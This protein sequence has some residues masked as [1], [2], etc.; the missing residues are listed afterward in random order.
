MS[1]VSV[2]VF[3]LAEYDA[4]HELSRPNDRCDCVRSK[5]DIKY[6]FKIY[7]MKYEN[8]IREIHMTII[9]P[10]AVVLQYTTF[11]QCHQGI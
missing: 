7:E 2:D 8:E 10:C 6:V 5:C 4:M 11:E 9:Y 3:F 1:T